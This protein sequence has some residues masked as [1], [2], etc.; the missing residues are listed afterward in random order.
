MNIL[1][2]G[3]GG[4]IGS[5]LVRTLAAESRDEI[6]GIVL[7]ATGFSHPRYHE[8]ELDLAGPDFRAR[9]PSSVDIVVHLAQ[10]LGYRNFPETANDLFAVNVD[11]T[12]RLL[13]WA[14]T[15]GVQKF[16]LASTGNVYEP[17]TKT[18][19]EAD[20][21]RPASFYGASKYAAEVLAGQYSHF[22]ETAILRIFGVYGPGQNSMMV[23]DMIRRVRTGTEITLAEGRGLV[24]TPVYVDDCVE[25][26]LRVIRLPGSGPSGV[27]NL[28]GNQ[29]VD[30][31]TIV[32]VLGRYLGKTPHTR[33]VDGP[34]TFFVGDSTKLYSRVGFL[35]RVGL[36]P[37]LELTVR[38]LEDAR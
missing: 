4:F 34:A 27:F 30:L 5:S 32:D 7:E 36:E 22:F 21:C 11:S 24:F 26:L 31:K 35:P 25:L 15:H 18:L 29:V 33:T 37:G 8:I 23:P 12:F 14:R 38:R 2:T 19:T 6:S 13:E 3:A 10:S 16:V 9:L 17:S 28:G 1:I 20:P